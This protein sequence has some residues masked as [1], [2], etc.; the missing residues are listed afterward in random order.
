MRNLGIYLPRKNARKI[1]IK[2]GPPPVPPD[3]QKK[4]NNRKREGGGEVEGEIRFF[5]FE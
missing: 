1:E 4:S 5:I 2:S 3:R